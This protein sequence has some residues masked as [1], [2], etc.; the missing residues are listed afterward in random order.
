VLYE[1]KKRFE[2]GLQTRRQVFN[3]AD[4]KPVLDDLIEEALADARMRLR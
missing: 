2:R 1:D 3:T 4:Q